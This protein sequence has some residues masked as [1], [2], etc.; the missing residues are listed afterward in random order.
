M[1]YL[2]VIPPGDR[3]SLLMYATGAHMVLAQ[4]L[5]DKRYASQYAAARTKGD[6]IMLDNGAAETERVGLDWLLAK[7]ADLDADEIVMPDVIGNAQA[8]IGLYAQQHSWV[9]GHKKVVIPHGQSIEEIVD[10]LKAYITI[11]PDFATIGVPKY[12]EKFGGRKALTTYIKQMLTSRYNI[13]WFGIYTN[14][15]KE[16]SEARSLGVRSIDSGAAVAYA[17]H[18]VSIESNTHV[19]LLWDTV[20]SESIAHSNILKMQ[21]RA[22]GNE[23]IL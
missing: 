13:H 21:W 9:P 5:S 7:A 4:H 14:P 11:N 18:G 19:P 12:S 2:P 16:I 17:Q 10:C 20:F 6:F 15:M 3:A 1:K 8:S 22:S 23:N